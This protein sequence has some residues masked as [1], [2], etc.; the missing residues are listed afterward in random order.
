MNL[1]DIRNDQLQMPPA[2]QV[3]P[4][5]FEHQHDLAIKYRPIEE[6]N[7]FWMPPIDTSTLPL[8]DAQF[9]NWIKNMFWRTVEELCE[10]VETVPRNLN[11]WRVMWSTDY[12]VR[13]F[14]EELGDATHFLVEVSIAVGVTGQEVA[15]LWVLRFAH[16]IQGF[17]VD[18][19]SLTQYLM[20]FI[21]DLG[22]AANCL[23]NKP[24]KTTHMQTD[25]AKFRE[26]LNGAWLKFCNIWLMLGCTLEDVYSLYRKKNLV[27]QF[28]QKSQY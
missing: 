11:S 24:W 1:D 14:F 10:A 18:Q 23:K 26:H 22:L 21:V 19:N 2:E 15:G 3:W 20:R 12:E 7:G 6:R 5:I 25:H 4:A 13:H 27:N 28:R 8:D 17:Q 9:Q 16:Q